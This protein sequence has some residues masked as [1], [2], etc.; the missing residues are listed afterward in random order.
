[1]FVHCFTGSEAVKRWKSLRDTY[2]KKK[3]DVNAPRSGAG[4]DEV[5]V[6]RWAHFKQMTFLNDTLEYTEYVKYILCTCS[7]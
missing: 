3:K 1:M 4:A 6:V 7:V 5:V 2:V